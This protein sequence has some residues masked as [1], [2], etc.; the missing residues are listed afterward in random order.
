MQ[1]LGSPGSEQAWACPVGWDWGAQ[2]GVGAI[3]TEAAPNTAPGF[4][5]PAVGRAV[6][7]LA[8]HLLFALIPCTHMPVEPSPCHVR[9]EAP[10]STTHYSLWDT[11]GN[12]L[13]E[14]RQLAPGH[15]EIKVRGWEHRG[16]G[17]RRIKRGPGPRRSGCSTPL[18]RLWVQGV[19]P[20]RGTRPTL[21]PYC[22][23]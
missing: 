1:R 6:R 20:G 7:G 3:P 17:V 22:V 10:S 15:T 18:P 11:A 23:V 2:G 13:R 19:G 9:P 5:P 12:W 4:P 8:A 16:V 21:S 14:G